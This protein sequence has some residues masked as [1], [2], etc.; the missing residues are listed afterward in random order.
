[1]EASL[2]NDFILFPRGDRKGDCILGFF[3]GGGLFACFV[4][5]FVACLG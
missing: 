2:S 3:S 4:S 1:M 5:Y